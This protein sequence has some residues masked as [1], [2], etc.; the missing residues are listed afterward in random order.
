MADSKVDLGAGAPGGY[1][2]G[3]AGY[4]VR[5]RVFVEGRQTGR[6][7][8]VALPEGDVLLDIS[9]Q[10]Y[11]GKIGVDV[12]SPGGDT[13][14][15]G[16]SGSYYRGSVDYPEE[17]QRY[18]APDRETYSARGIQSPEYS[19]YYQMK[20]GPR[21]EGYYRDMPEGS[22]MPDEYG[23]RVSYTVPFEE[24]GE[25]EQP[26]G[27]AAPLL[28]QDPS[29]DYPMNPLL[30]FASRNT[31]DVDQLSTDYME[32]D[33]KLIVPPILAD[34]FNAAV[35]G[36]QMLQNEA[37]VTSEGI[38]GV[39]L[40]TLPGS[41]L[42]SRVTQDAAMAG[43]GAVLGM[44]VFHGTPNLF[45]PEPGFPQGRPRLDKMG[46]GEGAQ[47]YGPGFYSAQS[48]DVGRGYRDDLT[49]ARRLQ[50]LDGMPLP[51]ASAFDAKKVAQDFDIPEQ[52][53]AYLQEII[54]DLD[55]SVISGDMDSIIAKL[56]SQLDL[57]PKSDADPETD[58]ILKALRGTYEAQLAVA[59][60]YK[61]RIKPNS[62]FLYKLDIPD[63]DAAK[64]LDYD[65]SI[66]EQSKEVL[67]KIEPII[68]AAKG[69]DPN[70]ATQ[71]NLSKIISASGN[72]RP[73]VT[74][75]MFFRGLAQDLGGDEA[76]ADALR[77]IGIPGLK[78][79]DQGSRDS[80]GGTRNFVVWDQDA[81]DR[82]K[83]LQ[84]NDEKFYAEGG[85][86]EKPVGIENSVT[87][88]QSIPANDPRSVALGSRLLKQAGFAG[89]F[90]S[91]LKNADPRV[92]EQ[93]NRI[94]ARGPA[95]EI[96]SPSNGLGVF[97]QSVMQQS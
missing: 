14:G 82:T 72:L 87:I 19:G 11:Y 81:L 27:A 36:G 58:E 47:A 71:S 79:L 15:G 33:T 26:M 66:T 78:Y 75:E 64:M 30:P 21:F 8:S 39:A 50:S 29:Y 7:P 45:K 77:K 43:P 32:G 69:Y 86:V 44:N 80:G 89:D 59:K 17:L 63:A 18:G 35:R 85:E 52:D 88:T 40:D 51:S 91:V 95:N 38:A 20:D 4:G 73:A 67:Q 94:M 34:M 49:Q 68:R 9:N 42:V 3:I 37:P 56:K 28:N 70:T 22:G 61:D 93:V 92:V 65:A 96:S 62:G 97:V 76:A 54:K 25:V 41:A 24:G 13:F 74:G 16:A 53:A 31:M 46:T 57:Y 2:F 48:R 83:V 90:R 5:P 84:R 6:T 10:S 55:S 1:S 23:G 12:T 60:K